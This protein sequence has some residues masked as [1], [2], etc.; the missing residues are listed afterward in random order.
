MGT[1]T[2]E[3]TDV[4]RFVCNLEVVTFVGL[5]LK[6]L[7]GQCVYIRKPVQSIAAHPL[8]IIIHVTKCDHLGLG[9]S[10]GHI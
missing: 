9:A 3:S 1:T 5:Q 6:S 8:F 2:I 7:I 4:F 10:Y